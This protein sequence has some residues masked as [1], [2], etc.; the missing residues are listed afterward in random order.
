[1]W[2]IVGSPDGSSNPL[3]I[4]IAANGQL[5]E[6]FAD[7]TNGSSFKC[8]KTPF[9]GLTFLVQLGKYLGPVYNSNNRAL[10]LDY[11]NTTVMFFNNM[12]TFTGTLS[13]DPWTKG[14]VEFIYPNTG[15][16]THNI[17]F[18]RGPDTDD[19]IFSIPPEI[20]CSTA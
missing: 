4:Y 6:I 18:T 17:A 13:L 14:P 2:E 12:F 3:S 11:A 16:Q 8:S 1:M 7:D 5:V 19:S 9:T 20:P 15:G 10:T